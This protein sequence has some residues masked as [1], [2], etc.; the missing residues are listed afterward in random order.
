MSSTDSPT[1]AEKGVMDER[2]HA[3]ASAGLLL[4]AALSL[5]AF[6]A[7]VYRTTLFGS[8]E[9]VAAAVDEM[10]WVDTEVLR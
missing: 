8:D 9:D 1:H 2:M 3:R 4:R 10:R 5:V 7:G 6:A